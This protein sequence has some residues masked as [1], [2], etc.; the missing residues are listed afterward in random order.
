MVIK[1]RE[2]VKKTISADY[3][4]ISRTI[5]FNGYDDYITWIVQNSGYYYYS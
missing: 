4:Q 3:I 2:M 1:N 5:Y